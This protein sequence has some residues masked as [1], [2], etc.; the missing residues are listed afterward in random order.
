MAT[1]KVKSGLQANLAAASMSNYELAFTTDTKGLYVYDG[2]NKIFVGRVI[3]D[4][5]SNI[6]SFGISGRY[7]YASDTEVLY[8]DTGSAWKTI[9]SGSG[10]SVFTKEITQ[11]FIIDDNSAFNDIVGSLPIISFSGSS[12]SIIRIKFDTDE[13]LDD[14]KDINFNITYCMSSSEISKQVSLNADAWIFS[15]SDSPTKSADQL[16]MEDEISVPS[17]QQIDNLNLTNIKINAANLS[18][19]RQSIALRLWRDISGV[20]SNHSGYFQLISVRAYQS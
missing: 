1:I 17:D 11:F 19:S 20:V 14:S 8:L 7:F 4:T 16:S 12:N 6:P 15:D 13:N 3:I 18:G 9:S 10:S 5:A 2:S